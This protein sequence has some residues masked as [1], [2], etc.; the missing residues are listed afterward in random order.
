MNIGIEL[1]GGLGNMMFQVAAGESF[2]IKENV[3]VYYPSLLSQFES[4]ERQSTW[5]LHAKEYLAMFK[6]F[7]WGLDKI[8]PDIKWKVVGVPFT[9]RPINLIDGELYKGYFQSEKNFADKNFVK[10]LFHPSDKISTYIRIKYSSIF[11]IGTTCSIHVRR[12]N[13][14]D[15]QKFHTLLE[16]D[17]YH[18]AMWTLQPFKVD[19]YLIFSNDIPWCRENFI[20]DKF[21]FIE[22]TDYVEMFLQAKCTHHIIANSAFSWWGAWLGD[23][24]DTVIIAPK[25]W[26]PINTA[27]S[28]DIIPARWIKL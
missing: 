7:N 13:Y 18:K 27:D 26:F 17:Y 23:I 14:C 6:N 16:M 20:G 24:W 21:V 22:D 15:L 28:K 3:N 4:L 1:M 19:K 2:S 9:Y 8:D 12:G 25:N 11:L 5:T 10:M